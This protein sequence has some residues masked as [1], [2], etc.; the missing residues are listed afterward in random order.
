V[1]DD[2]IETAWEEVLAQFDDEAA[3]KR[4]L[5]LAAGL[6]ALGEAG[7]RYRAIKDDPDDP[8]AEMAAA[9]V[10]RLLGLAMQNLEPLKTPPNR[11]KN[12]KTVMFLLALGVSGT[13]VAHAVWSLLRA[14]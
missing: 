13:L 9:Q 1:T 4:F 14:M 5:T 6:G 10:D 11:K 7:R 8:R 2:A 3:H 12:I